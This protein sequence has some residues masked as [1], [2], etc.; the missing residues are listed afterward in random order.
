M[1]SDDFR[2]SA[3]STFGSVYY[4]LYNQSCSLEFNGWHLDVLWLWSSEF[5]FSISTYSDHLFRGSDIKSVPS[6]Q[7]HDWKIFKHQQRLF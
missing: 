7:K 3:G 6:N 1:I 2:F 4:I 5:V